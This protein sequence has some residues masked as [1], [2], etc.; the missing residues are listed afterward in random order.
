LAGLALGSLVPFSA[1]G[2]GPIALPARVAGVLIPSSAVAA[3]AA[4]L[5]Q[6]SC[7]DFLFNHCM[8]TFVFGALFMQKQGIAYDA[9]QAFVAASLHDIGLL[10]GYASAKGSFEI[11]GADTAEKSCSTTA[12]Q[13]CEPISSG[14]RWKCM[15]ASGR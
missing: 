10:P 6:Q 1:L 8:R 13:A 7:P 15:M 9:D 12:L 14:M 5:A 11:D 2:A 4:A 3:A